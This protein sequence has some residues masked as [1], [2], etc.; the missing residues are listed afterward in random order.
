MVRKVAGTY[1]LF[2]DKEDKDMEHP[3]VLN[4]TGYFIYT[5]LQ[6]GIP[7][8]E[9]AN[10]LASNYHISYDEAIIDVRSCETDLNQFLNVNNSG[11]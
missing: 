6:K 9:I 1:Y 3:C 5:R 8:E 2:S 4:E 7:V 11:A 10:E